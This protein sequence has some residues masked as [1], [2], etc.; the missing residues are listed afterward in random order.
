M[1]RANLLTTFLTKSLLLAL[2][3]LKHQLTQIFAINV[4]KSVDSCLKLYLTMA[5]VKEC[6]LKDMFLSLWLLLNK[7]L[8][9][10]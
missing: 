9:R 5:Y 8:S 7:I 2:S 1:K 6:L 10:L 3:P 4:F